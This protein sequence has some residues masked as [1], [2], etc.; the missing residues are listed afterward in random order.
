MLA[1]IGRRVDAD[2]RL[3]VNGD[4]AIM[5]VIELGGRKFRIIEKGTLEHQMWMDRQVL[6][7]G[8]SGILREA[9]MSSA[10]YAG[11]IWE[12][13]S[14][15]QKVF[16]LLSGMLIPEGLADVDWTPAEA[17]KTTAFLKK[18]T[19]PEDHA[20]VRS[21]LISVVLGF[22]GAAQNYAELSG[23]VSDA[24]PAAASPREAIPALSL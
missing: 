17:D 13:I 12:Q 7:T 5:E 8:L 14:R 6:E 2:S 22:F 16:P 18:L 15:Q 4:G 23:I 9:P 11:K 3:L 24:R 10:D 1:G 21:L 20:R 19:A